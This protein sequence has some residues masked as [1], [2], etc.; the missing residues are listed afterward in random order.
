MKNASSKDRYVCCS[1]GGFI[2]GDESQGF[3]IAQ[4]APGTRCVSVPENQRDKLGTNSSPCIHNAMSDREG[5]A[6]LLKDAELADKKGG[7][8][9]GHLG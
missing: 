1:N 2:N 4:C 8:S 7:G 6:Q 9:A 5:I 3:R